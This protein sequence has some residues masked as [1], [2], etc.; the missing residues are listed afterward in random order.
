MEIPILHI[1]S[2]TV[3]ILQSTVTISR[4]YVKQHATTTVSSRIIQK[5]VS[6]RVQSVIFKVILNLETIFTRVISVCLR[7]LVI[8]MQIFK[9]I[10]SVCTV[11]HQ[12]LSLHSEKT[13]FASLIV[14]V[15]HGAIR[16]RIV[17]ARPAVRG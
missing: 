14:Q 6:K 9:P 7:A 16:T 1:A 15:R 4:V 2:L 13:T 8:L 11:A 12:H 3:Q 5:D 10:V 17:H